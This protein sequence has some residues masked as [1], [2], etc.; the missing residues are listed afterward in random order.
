[1]I[2][3]EEVAQV[4]ISAYHQKNPESWLTEIEI[5]RA[6]YEAKVRVMTE[7]E[8]DEYVANAN[9]ALEEISTY[10]EA[11]IVNWS[12]PTER[13]ERYA[14]ERN[15]NL[16]EKELKK[17]F[18]KIELPEYRLTELGYNALKAECAKDDMPIKPPEIGDASPTEGLFDI[19]NP[20]Q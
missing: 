9:L 19:N 8:K 17:R 7:E 18:G 11:W 12:T 10:I 6:L 15:R 13:K 3:L 4:M 14:L 1:M 16:T 2:S 20:L 5:F